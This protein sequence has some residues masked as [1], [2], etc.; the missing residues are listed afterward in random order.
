M[1]VA[2]TDVL[3]AVRA[4]WA[5][6]ATLA[7]LVP[8]ARVYTKRDAERT[9][10]P[11]ATLAADLADVQ[12]TT[13]PALVAWTVKVTVYAETD[14]GIQA[15]LRAV[16][17]IFAGLVVA[18]AVQTLPGRPLPGGGVEPTGERVAGAD[19]VSG[20]RAFRVVTAVAGWLS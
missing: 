8:A 10:T 7:G 17:A 3:D 9:A 18:G 11:R 19:V 1:A 14:T 5:A 6:D 2:A 16:P 20:V 4:A 13:G 12:T 15:V